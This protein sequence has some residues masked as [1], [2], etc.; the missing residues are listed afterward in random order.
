MFEVLLTKRTKKL[1]N[2]AKKAGF[3]RVFFIEE[4][5]IVLLKTTNK[6]ELRREITRA[7]SKKKRI[8]VFGSTDEINRIAVEDKRVSMLLS[9]EKDKSKDFMKYRNSG[10][11]HVLC[12]IATKNNIA[13]GIA[14]ESIK[15]SKGLERAEKIGKMS[16]NVALCNKYKTKIVLA[17][18][19]KKISSPHILRS[20]G[21]V[22][23]M[24]T[25]QIKQSIENAEIVFG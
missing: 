20:F 25:N 16:Q 24:S 1:E 22:I 17:S 2:D 14:F 7:A 23:G 13:I 19:S 10:L 6:E 4:E 11:N 5:G 3:D 12:K 8:I 18:F 15:S 9:P 21:F